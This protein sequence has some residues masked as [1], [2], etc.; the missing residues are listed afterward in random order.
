MIFISVRYMELAILLVLALYSDIKTYKIKNY[1][2]IPFMCIGILTNLFFYGLHGLHESLLGICYPIGILMVLFM[3]RMLGA[4]DMKLFGAIGAIM[5]YSFVLDVIIYSFLAG[6]II[7]IAILIKRQ[8]F[9]QQIRYL[10][11]YV[12][13]CF[14]TFSTIPYM[15]YSDK[16]NKSRFHFS[17]AIVIGTLIKIYLNRC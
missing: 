16:N 17:I 3:L 12:K 10:I 13:T 11:T 6:G 8:N 14:L 1:I 9:V 7:S 15:D 2:T 5:G 4:G